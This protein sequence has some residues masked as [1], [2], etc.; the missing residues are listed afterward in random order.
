MATSHSNSSYS[1]SDFSAYGQ[2]YNQFNYQNYASYPEFY[3]SQFAAHQ[4][5]KAGNWS[6]EISHDLRSNSSLSMPHHPHQHGSFATPSTD[7]YQSE[8]YC[9]QYVPANYPNHYNYHSGPQPVHSTTSTS[10]DQQQQQQ[11][12]HHSEFYRANINIYPAAINSQNFTTNNKKRKSDDLTDDDKDSDNT[13]H[14]SPAL[15]ALLNAPA[16]KKCKYT[17]SNFYQQFQSQSAAKTSISSSNVL[18]PSSSSTTVA[19]SPSQAMLSPPPTVVPVEE[20]INLYEYQQQQQQHPRTNYHH[21]QQ[22]QRTKDGYEPKPVNHFVEEPVPNPFIAQ[23][24]NNGGSSQYQTASHPHQQQHIVSEAISTPPLS[25]KDSHSNHH[26]HVNHMI[27][28]SNSALSCSPAN[29]HHSYSWIQ[30]GNYH[31]QCHSSSSA[32]ARLFPPQILKSVPELID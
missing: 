15:R 26:Q 8:M 13:N 5:M 22:Q 12:Q 24:Q 18:S 16:T 20:S 29:S 14:D 30:N 1:G 4:S 7:V 28:N 17:P 31:C 11:Q 9:S 6:S 2:F 23:Y 3:S 25:P 21:L 10:N 27:E 19:A 32:S